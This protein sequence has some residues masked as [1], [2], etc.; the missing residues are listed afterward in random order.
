MELQKLLYVDDD[1][2]NLRFFEQ[3]FCNLFNITTAS[4]G[5]AGLEILQKDPTIHIVISDW[6]MPE[7]DG[8]EFIQKV[9]ELDSSIVCFMITSFAGHN[10]LQPMIEGG[11]IKYSFK[12]PFDKGLIVSKIKEYSQINE[13]SSFF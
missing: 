11:V 10:E 9:K 12:K 6:K 13:H 1:T 4:S 2:V 3:I 7:M 8:V 5:K